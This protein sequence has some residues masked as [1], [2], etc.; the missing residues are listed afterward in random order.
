MAISARTRSGIR[1]SWD[2]SLTYCNDAEMMCI[3]T[4]G[5]KELYIEEIKKYYA[6]IS[7]LRDQ[8]SILKKQLESS[9]TFKV[10]L[11]QID[12]WLGEEEVSFNEYDDNIIRY[13]ISSIRVTEDLNLIISIKGGCVIIEPIYANVK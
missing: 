1:I 10:E 9:D 11:Q 5:N 7:Q 2:C 8:M 13:L 4:E 3:R 6:T 12:D